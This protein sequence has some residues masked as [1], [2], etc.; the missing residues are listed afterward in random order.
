MY[1]AV[2]SLIL[3]ALVV[4]GIV[5]SLV[6]ALDLSMSVSRLVHSVVHSV[7]VD[8]DIGVGLLRG[9]FLL[10]LGVLLLFISFLASE[11]LENVYYQIEDAF[12]Q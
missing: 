7:N 4:P 3:A 2:V 10:V 6:G 8:T 11:P 9:F 12:L 1:S 5:L